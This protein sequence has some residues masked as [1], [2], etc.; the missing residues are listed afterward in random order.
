MIAFHPDVGV[1]VKSDRVQLFDS[2]LDG[3][4]IVSKE[5]VTIN[6]LNRSD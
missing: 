3:T 1:D 5:T 6:E 4:R 2:F